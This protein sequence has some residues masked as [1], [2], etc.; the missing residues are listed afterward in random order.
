MAGA[1][2]FSNPP[3]H[4]KWSLE[5]LEYTGGP[6][7]FWLLF[8]DWRRR[9]KGPKQFII[10][11]ITGPGYG[12]REQRGILGNKEIKYM[13]I[14]NFLRR[15]LEAFS[16]KAL[17]GLWHNCKYILCTVYLLHHYQEK[18]YHR[19]QSGEQ[20]RQNS[21]EIRNTRTRALWGS[22]TINRE[23]TGAPKQKLLTNYGQ[24]AWSIG[25][26]WHLAFWLYTVFVSISSRCMTFISP[27]WSL[28][29]LF[30]TL[31]PIHSEK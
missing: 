4:V 12:E 17:I 15:W 29:Q 30:R 18:S 11:L 24:G 1:R 13:F 16:L 7:I 26:S 5:D 19:S 10:S 3:W 6:W 25:Q 20:R 8:S 14:L 21:L 9:V 23:M 28:G 22:T 31:F 27:V 2:V